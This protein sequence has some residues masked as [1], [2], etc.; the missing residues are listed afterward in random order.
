VKRFQFEQLILDIE[1]K[2][3]GPAHAQIT[4]ESANNSFEQHVQAAET[5]PT[6]PGV[7]NTLIDMESL[8]S[9]DRQFN[10]GQSITNVIKIGYQ[11]YKP[12]VSQA[13]F[14]GLA[15]YG[16]D[17]L[18]MYGFYQASRSHRAEMEA[19]FGLMI[20][21]NTVLIFGLYYSIDEKIGVATGLAYGAQDYAQTRRVLRQGFLTI[22]LLAVVYFLPVVYFSDKLLLSLGIEENNSHEVRALLLKLYPVDV[23]RMLNEIMLTFSLA[24]GVNFNYGLYAVIN[25]VISIVTA[26]ALDWAFDLGIDAWLAARLV[27]EVILTITYV[28]PFLR[29]IDP[30]TIWK[31]KPSSMKKGSQFL[32]LEQ[33]GLDFQNPAEET[34]VFHGYGEFLK[35]CAKYSISLYSEWLGLEIAIFFTSQTKNDGQIAAH[36]AIANISYF[37]VNTGLGFSTVGRVRINM[38]LGQGL[39]QAAKVFFQIFMTGSLFVGMILSTFL[40]VF[41][42]HILDIYGGANLDVKEWLE[43]LLLWYVLFLPLDF[44]FP[45]L[46][47]VCRSTNHIMLTSLLNVGLLICASSAID[48]YLVYV[49]SPQATCV[50]LLIVMYTLIA[51]I[52]STITFKLIRTDWKSI[53]AVLEDD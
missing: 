19:S 31:P 32:L 11:V 51:C 37:M 4:S 47:T 10:D 27:H 36:T 24:Q 13:L 9:L 48:Y 30:R 7:N 25:M 29:L 20:F 28:Y 44:M 18:N 40:L 2:K 49:K 41:K 15:N 35:D 6:V 52:F 16:Y 5:P 42:S 21:F 17:L 14:L 38:L 33:E 43:K 50:E 12:L 53:V 1:A 45:F 39:K 34:S 23:A 8:K 26:V 3:A 46:F 22:C